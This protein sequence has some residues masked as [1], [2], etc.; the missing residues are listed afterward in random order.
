MTN[1]KQSTVVGGSRLG[2]ILVEKGVVSPEI[3][4]QALKIQSDGDPYSSKRLE[5]ILVSNFKI[6]PDAVFGTLAELY[7]F[8]TYRVNPEK[9]DPAQI[10]HTKE[11][12]AKFPDE[13]KNQ[14]LY[15]KVLPYQVING[16]RNRLLVLASNP[17]EK[18]VEKIPL[19]TEFK[20]YEVVYTPLKTIEELI[21]LISPRENEFLDLLKEAV[22]E[23]EISEE[24]RITELDEYS[25]DEEIN[26]SLLVNLYEGCLIEAVRRKASDIHIIPYEKN[27]VDI[28]FRI[29]GR[30]QLWYRQE[31]VSPEAMSAVV[32]DRTIGVDRFERDTAQD[33]F[34]QRKVDNYLIRYRVS[35]LPIISEE[36][37][38]R[39]ES[40]VIRII[41]DR[42]VI[43]DLKLLGFLPQAEADFQRA[44]SKSKGIV[45]LTG[46]TGSGKSTTL[47]AA[48]HHVMDESKNILT[49][50]DPVEYAIKGAR[51]LK[52]GRKL[53]FEDAIRTIL[54]HDPDIVMV[55][56]IRDK[57]T[58]DVAV[59]LANTGHL[60]FTTLHTNDA[61]SAISRLYKMGVE[62]FL[63]A[64]AINIIVAQ[65]LVRKLCPF[66]RVPLAPEKFPAALELGLTEEDLQSGKIFDAGPGCKKCNSGYK[67]RISLAEALYF[68]PEVRKS[69]LG[70]GAEVN[71]DEIRK[72]AEGQGMLSILDS[73]LEK[74]REGATTI[75]EVSYAASEG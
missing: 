71:E 32:K 16:S 68:S 42:N 50:E 34:F 45:I 31:N 67:G 13:L 27:N 6:D 2:Q 73:G 59:K 61:P 48:L 28:Y 66:C 21:D 1:D 33:G 11:I 74:I 29:D 18:V 65:R 14:L 38:R 75:S 39:F 51:Q 64:Y 8:R 23:P 58:A 4:E 35:V 25:L 5:D 56:E 72:I 30:L 15:Y 41:D 52:I 60:T 20:K 22:V 24:K 43:A 40:I 36:Y 17:T 53:S 55:G 63:L 44:I 47:L 49:I 46:P 57:I 62:P 37:E 70:S 19:L 9:L 10:K 7:A 12:L 3:L 26:K 54:R 69:I